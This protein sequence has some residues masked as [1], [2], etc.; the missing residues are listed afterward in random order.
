MVVVSAFANSMRLGSTSGA[1]Y[2]SLY[3]MLSL[4]LGIDQVANSSFALLP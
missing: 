2:F 4:Q 1:A 3:R